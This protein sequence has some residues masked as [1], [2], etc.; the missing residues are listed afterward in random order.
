MELQVDFDTLLKSPRPLEGLDPLVWQTLTAGAKSKDHPWNVGAVSTI[1]LD[2]SEM[3][4]P[5]ARSVI[6]RSVGARTLDFHTDARSA[7]VAQISASSTPAPIC[8]LFYDPAAKIQLRLD[9]VAEILDGH[10]AD[11]AWREVP[12][13]SRSAYL[14][15]SPPGL[16]VRGPQ[17]PDTRD[18]FVPQAESERGRT[19]FRIVRTRAVFAD[20]LYLRREGHV[21]ASLSYPES[22]EVLCRWLVP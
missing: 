8:W 3:Q 14:S 9:G 5:Q 6:L 10:P 7:K 15:V 22:G 20:W 17:P 11:E 1:G 21:R 13:S 12:L 18:R 2:R 4:F 16:A 19:N